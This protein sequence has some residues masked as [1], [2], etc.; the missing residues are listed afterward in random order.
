MHYRPFV[1][2]PEHYL[3][4]CLL[5]LYLRIRVFLLASLYC[6]IEQIPHILDI[7]KSSI[8]QKSNCI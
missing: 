3:G 4:N 7:Y 5:L 2:A 8:Y 1:L 6:G